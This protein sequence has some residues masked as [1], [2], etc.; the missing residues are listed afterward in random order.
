MINNKYMEKINKKSLLIL[1]VGFSVIGL[2]GLVMAAA[3][4]VPLGAADGFAILA[5]STITNTGATVIDGDLGLS[6]GTSVTNFP[7]GTV[8]NGIQRIN[9]ATAIQAQS[10]LTTA[11]NN[12]AGQGCD[13][14]LTGQD[15]GGMTLTPGVYCFDN[16]AQ[17]TGTLTLNG[18]NN[19]DSVFI[20]QIGT[21]LTTASNSSVVFTNDTQAC[22]VFWKVGS[23]ATLGTD[24]AFQGNILALASATLNTRASVVG[25]VLAST[26]AITLDTNTVTKATCAATST[27]LHIIKHVVNTGGG[28]AT[29]SLFNLHVKNSGGSEVASSPAAGA[30]APGTTYSLASGTYTVS[31]DAYASYTQSF[32]GDCNSSGSVVLSGVAKTCTITNTYVPPASATLHVIKLV[33]DG[34]AGSSPSDFTI[35]VKDS[36]GAEVCIKPSSWSGCTWNCLFSF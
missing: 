21:T 28:T 34:A 22:H 30:E 24:T 33:V 25:R 29:A 31:E 1:L 12:A 13:H 26:G 8:I 32:S 35:H 17:L 10:D 6:P 27:T 23:S 11:Y 15:L 18:Q 7:P 36:L 20:F 4:T 5:N 19:P 16:S 3:T 14:N 2:A 9:D